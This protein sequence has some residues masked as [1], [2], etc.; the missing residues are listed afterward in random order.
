M[1]HPSQIIG[2]GDADQR[3]K[4]EVTDSSL[5]S[6]QARINAIDGVNL[7]RTGVPRPAISRKNSTIAISLMALSATDSALQEI[8]GGAHVHGGWNGGHACDQG[9]HKVIVACQRRDS[10]RKPD[11]LCPSCDA[12]ASSVKVQLH[13]TDL[14]PVGAVMG[15]VWGNGQP[16]KMR[17]AIRLLASGLPRPS[18]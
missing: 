10:V 7:F 11:W 4:T 2:A 12:A 9:Y 3:F 5:W 6:S 14:L 1:M 18:T 17:S 16:C 8:G 15:S 13:T